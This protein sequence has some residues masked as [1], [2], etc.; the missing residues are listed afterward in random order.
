MIRKFW[1]VANIL[2]LVDVT[3]QEKFEIP[4]IIRARLDFS[5]VQ[6]CR[7]ASIAE[8]LGGSC[9]WYCNPKGM[10]TIMIKQIFKRWCL[11]QISDLRSSRIFRLIIFYLAFVAVWRCDK[12]SVSVKSWQQTNWFLRETNHKLYSIVL[13]KIE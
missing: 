3:D 4:L 12:S 11:C 1:K 9:A 6:G 10:L 7:K 13:I 5:I 2:I 8:L